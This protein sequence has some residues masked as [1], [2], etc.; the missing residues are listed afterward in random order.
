MTAEDKPN[1]G[2]QSPIDE[3]GSKAEEV[4]DDNSAFVTQDELV[5]SHYNLVTSPGL[6]VEIS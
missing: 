2:G 4:E 5:S 6:M 1:E 3:V